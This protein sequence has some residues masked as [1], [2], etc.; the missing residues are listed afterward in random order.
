M[1]GRLAAG[2]LGPLL[3]LL[4]GV[5]VEVASAE[6]RPLVVVGATPIH[7]G[8]RVGPRSKEE[9]I[10][11]GLRAGVVRVA[12]ELL[13]AQIAAD[14]AARAEAEAIAALIAALTEDS[15][16]EPGSAL[17]G[18]FD[19][20]ALDSQA[21]DPQARGPQARGP[22]ALDPSAVGEPEAGAGNAGGEPQGFADP[23]SAGY[24]RLPVSRE[25]DPE[26]DARARL[27][28]ETLAAERR[29][30]RS[31]TQQ[32]RKALGR[33]M[34]PYTKSFRIVEDQGERQALFSDDPDVLTEYVVLLEVQVEVERVRARLEEAG[35][36][37]PREASPLTG[38]RLEVYG[39]THYAGYAAL[40]ALLQSEAVGAV[41]VSPLDFARGRVVLRVEGEWSPE[42]LMERLTT[43]APPNLSIEVAGPGAVLA[44]LGWAPDSPGPRGP[45]RLVLR[46]AWAPLPPPAEPGSDPAP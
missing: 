38:I 44:P 23:F 9:A 41:G 4:T 13:D 14:A 19:S 46:A 18:A 45:S 28:E 34:V 22:Q 5:G 8:T 43:E 25:S 12:R 21:L 11:Q 1:R 3:A 32:I 6:V 24:G 35:A 39:L 15:R 26:A 2:W 16:A 36:L 33:E 29:A 10:D 20:Q 17:S 42:E 30:L 37:R 31:Q 27:A 40:L 7:T